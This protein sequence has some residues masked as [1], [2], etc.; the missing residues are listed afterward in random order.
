M[1]TVFCVFAI[2]ALLE[3]IYSIIS[4]YRFFR[5]VSSEVTKPSKDYALRVALI[6]PCR[7]V[8]PGFEENISSLLTQNYENFGVIFVT[9]A[10]D[11]SCQVLDRI[12]DGDRSLEVKL[13]K[14]DRSK[15]CGQ[16]VWNLTRAVEQVGNDTEVLAFADSDVRVDP[17]WLRN[18]VG[19]LTEPQVGA[20]TG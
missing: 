2:I 18:L 19:A 17:N 5:F 9:T 11:E 14:S 6:I 10:D 12:V 3:G 7:G 1:F 13:V 16:K 4:G 8:D 20:T 15:S